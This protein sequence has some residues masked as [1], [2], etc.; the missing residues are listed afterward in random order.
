MTHAAH[1][2][3]SEALS[4]LAGATTQ[5]PSRSP[6][7]AARTSASGACVTAA[8]GPVKNRIVT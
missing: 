5:C 6:S 7:R 1:A 2:D 8:C 4:D 3:L